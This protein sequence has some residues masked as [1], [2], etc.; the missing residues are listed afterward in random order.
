MSF[1]II[2][3]IFVFVKNYIDKY[4]ILIQKKELLWKKSLQAE[5]EEKAKEEK[6]TGEI[7][8]KKLNLIP[9]KQEG[10]L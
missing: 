5:W 3:K 10:L 1:A 8:I 2:K 4:V 9:K 7:P 6:A